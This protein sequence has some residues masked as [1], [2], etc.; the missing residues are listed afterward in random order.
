[1]TQKAYMIRPAKQTSQSRVPVWQRGALLIFGPFVIA[2]ASSTIL[3]P[4]ATA[5]PLYS[6]KFKPS[7]LPYPVPNSA[8]TNTG[9]KL[10]LEGSWTQVPGG[11]FFTGNIASAYSLGYTNSLPPGGFTLNVP[12][13]AA[14]GVTVRFTFQ[15]PSGSQCTD[16]QNITQVGRF[17]SKLAQVKLQLSKSGANCTGR[18][19]PQCRIAGASS[20][21]ND[22][23][24]T[25][26]QALV[27]G[28]NY[29]LKCI[30]LPDSTVGKRLW[31]QTIPTDVSTTPIPDK[32]NWNPTGLVRSEPDTRLSV[33]NKHPQTPYWSY[34][35][36]VDGSRLGI[37][38]VCCSGYGVI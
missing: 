29:I 33:A 17:G 23:P 31:L 19:F 2:L 28:K 10:Q 14:V 32:S 16:S 4:A 35:V 36:F 24:V 6:Y 38:A 7:P 20:S 11:V 8:G 22:L 27:S 37:Q 30:K 26:K 12:S 9:V 25:G 1:M 21:T 18:V 5:G 3:A 34:P 13:T 15:T